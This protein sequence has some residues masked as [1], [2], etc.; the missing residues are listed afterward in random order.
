MYINPE[1]YKMLV[2]LNGQVRMF[3]WCLLFS[4]CPQEGAGFFNIDN[5]EYE[6]MP[7]EIRL[8][9]RKLHFFCSGERREQLL[10]EWDSMTLNNTDYITTS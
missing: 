5:E 3:Y 10:A 8:L 9:P 6:A 1:L 7:V 4:P 2:L